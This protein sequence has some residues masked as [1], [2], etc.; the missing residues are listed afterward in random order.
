M[1]RMYIPE[2][3]GKRNTFV[4]MIAFLSRAF[5]P[6]IQMTIKILKYLHG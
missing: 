1:E 5:L 2:Q 4:L 6:R 3:S